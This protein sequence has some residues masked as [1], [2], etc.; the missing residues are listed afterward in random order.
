[1]IGLL[2]RTCQLLGIAGGAR[3]C[4]PLVKVIL[5]VGQHGLLLPSEAGS[6]RAITS[7]SKSEHQAVQ[8]CVRIELA[9]S[10]PL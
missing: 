8:R 4:D 3:S 6:G 1:M 7:R 5:L 10:D 2:I 9:R